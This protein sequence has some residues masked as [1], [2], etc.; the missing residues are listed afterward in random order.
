MSGERYDPVA[1]PYAPGA[2]TPPPTLVGRDQ[3]IDAAD[4]SLRRLVAKR[5]TQHL[6]LT[7]L[8]G[9]GKTVLLGTLAAVAEHVGFR[10]IRH[11]A[12][13]GDDTIA[14]LLRQ[15]RRILDDL[16]PG[17]RVARA[18]PVDRLGVAHD[19]GYG[20]QGRQGAWRQRRPGSTRRCRHRP[21]HGSR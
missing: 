4:I 19:R 21:R 13:G 1:N 9:V 18:F 2:G 16:E 12:V 8:R 17:P 20:R 5:S 3:L 6:M 7:G 14:S 15:A 10:V 11:E